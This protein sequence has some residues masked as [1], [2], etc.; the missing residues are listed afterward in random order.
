[1][2]ILI[3]I[4][5]LVLISTS[6]YAKPKSIRMPDY[7]RN[8]W[9]NWCNE[10]AGEITFGR[11]ELNLRLEASSQEWTPYVIA[12]LED[13]FQQINP[14]PSSQKTAVANTIALLWEL[15]EELKYEMLNNPEPFTLVEVNETYGRFLLTS[16]EFIE[17]N[18][19]F[20]RIHYIPAYYDYG[21]L[22]SGY[23]QRFYEFEENYL[24]FFLAA[25]TFLNEQ[26]V[27]VVND[28]D[29]PIRAKITNRAFLLAA[30]KLTDFVEPEIL[31]SL[32]A[33]TLA[34]EMGV[35]QKHNERRLATY[36]NESRANPNLRSLDH[37]AKLAILTWVK[38]DNLLKRS[39]S[40][41]G[42]RRH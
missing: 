10:T 34:C 16:L 39:N 7:D 41:P 2:K 22:Q 1:M 15:A 6:A 17:Q 42:Y 23:Q 3:K 26:L 35:L 38:V 11:E 20:D 8:Y 14:P 4:L 37:E 32:R 31:S 29:N 5:T 27:N 24:K 30:I 25:M 9:N 36:I 33:S 40:C 18:I 21:G 12:A 19:N 13:T 28:H